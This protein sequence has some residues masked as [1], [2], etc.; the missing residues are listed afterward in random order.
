MNK[1]VKLLI[2]ASIS[3]VLFYVYISNSTLQ[4]SVPSGFYEDDFW[5]EIKAPSSQ[6]YY[7]LDGSTP[8][9]DSTLYTGPIYIT[10]A[11]LNENVYSMREDVSSY[12]LE[13]LIV[14]HTSRESYTSTYKTPDYLIDKGTII[15]AVYYDI[16]GEP[17][18]MNTATYFVGFEEKSGYTDYKTISVVTAPDN[19]FDYDTGIYVLGSTFEKYL[20]AGNINSSFWWWS[21]NYSKSGIN[22]ERAADILI[23]DEKGILELQKEVGIRVQGGASR[24]LY[25]KSLNVYARSAYDGTEQVEIPIWGNMEGGYFPD[26]FTIAS[27]GN[28]IYTKFKDRLVSELCQDLEVATLQYEPY[29]MFLNGEYWGVCHLAEKYTEAYFHYYYNVDPTNVVI[30]KAGGLESGD[31]KDYEFFKMLRTFLNKEDLDLSIAENYEYLWTQIDQASTVDYFALKLYFGR[32]GD[33]IPLGANSALWKT[34][35]QGD[36]VVEDGIW[37]WAVYDMNSAGISGSNNNVDPIANTRNRISW[38]DSLCNN[39]DFVTL[40]SERLLELMETDFQEERIFGLIDDYIEEME[41][42]MANHYMRFF[43]S[44]LTKFYNQMEDMRTFFA[45]RNENMKRFI[46]ENFGEMLD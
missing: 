2:T 36:G 28:D 40:L 15:R 18:E 41:D 9:K 3:F 6:I 5:L 38:F 16:F 29:N 22:W 21:G 34:S 32:T 27:G 25:P 19:L 30:I 10:D 37:R 24:A 4:F 43:G 8:T 1:Q 20:E 14:E 26:T 33:W 11:S 35:Y 12:F 39:Q 45:G 44:G 46:E 17:K 7:T 23:Y 42:A 31:D 13:E